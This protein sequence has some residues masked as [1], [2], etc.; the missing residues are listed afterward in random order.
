[1]KKI[2]LFTSVLFLVFASNLQSQNIPNISNVVISDSILCNGELGELTIDI[3][4][5]VPA[6]NPLEIVVGSFPFSF[7]PACFVKRKSF[8]FTTS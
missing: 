6:T 8:K 1:M 5:S 4:Q 2:L 7:N 3:S